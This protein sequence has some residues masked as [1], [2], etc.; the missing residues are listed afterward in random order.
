MQSAGCPGDGKL[1]GGACTSLSSGAVFHSKILA[2][3]VTITNSY[4]KEGG[5]T[6]M[7]RL[8]YSYK[9]TSHWGGTFSQSAGTTKYSTC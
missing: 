4:V 7:A 5:G 2:A 3:S 1:G 6:I 9:G 8:G